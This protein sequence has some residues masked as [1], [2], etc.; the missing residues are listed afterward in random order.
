MVVQLLT[1]WMILL[2][3][4]QTPL[5]P[6]TSLAWS[7]ELAAV[8]YY[9]DGQGRYRQ[10]HAVWTSHPR[11]KTKSDPFSDD[12]YTTETLCVFSAPRGA[13]KEGYGWHVT[14][15]PLRESES[16]LVVRVDWRRTKDRGVD[17]RSPAAS[18]E[19]T[20]QPGDRIPLDYII[21]GPVP[22][23]SSC[24]A[25]GMA[26]ELRLGLPRGQENTLIQADL[27]LVDRGADDKETVTPITVRGPVHESLSYF[28]PDV[29]VSTTTGTRMLRVSGTLLARPR[30]DGTIDLQFSVERMFPDENRRFESGLYDVNR[31]F[32]GILHQT[33]EA[34]RVLSVVLPKRPGDAL[35]DHQV[36]VRVRVRRLP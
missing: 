24:K 7:L 10:D 27:W 13:E 29:P 31:E 28:F 16:E 12:L 23:G 3:G 2:A 35:A 22:A 18:T 20:L 26:L 1:T 14:M 6:P 8:V 30:A 5:P 11:V 21:P 19:F 17:V 34:N 36:S 33:M 9:P 32:G 15:T 4:A 25:S